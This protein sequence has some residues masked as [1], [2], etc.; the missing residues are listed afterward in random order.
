MQQQW[1]ERQQQCNSSWKEAYLTHVCSAYSTSQ[2]PCTLDHDTA[3]SH[4]AWG[5]VLHSDV[6]SPPPPKSRAAG[7]TWYHRDLEK[8]TRWQQESCT[9]RHCSRSEGYNVSP[10]CPRRTEKLQYCFGV[11]RKCEQG[12]KCPN[13]ESAKKK[14]RWYNVASKP[15]CS[16]DRSLQVYPYAHVQSYLHI[17]VTKWFGGPKIQKLDTEI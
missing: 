15:F 8:D 14:D 9:R 17:F 12:S 6:H 10:L 13:L 3:L 7:T 2:P 16:R 5:V 11:T 1:S 4:Y